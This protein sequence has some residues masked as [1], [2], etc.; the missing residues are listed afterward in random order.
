VA[1]VALTAFSRQQDVDRAL[2]AGFDAHC[3][4]PLRPL[5]LLRVIARVTRLHERCDA[6]KAAPP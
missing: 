4:K 3:A 1:A 6:R 5:D 2:A